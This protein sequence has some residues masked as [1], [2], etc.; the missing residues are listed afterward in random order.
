MVKTLVTCQDVV[1][2][3]NGS[4]KS[5]TKCQRID[6]LAI[7]MYGREGR[8]SISKRR[9]GP[10]TTLISAWAFSGLPET[11]TRTRYN[12]QDYT[13]FNRNLRLSGIIKSEKQGLPNQKL[14][15]YG[16]HMHPCFANIWLLSGR[17]SVARDVLWAG[18]LIFGSTCCEGWFGRSTF[19]FQVEGLF[20][21]GDFP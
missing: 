9:L 16:R 21:M 5:D 4:P 15:D 8:T 7:A 10:T 2:Y 3:K 19:N 11:S 14:S 1:V 18:I 12:R 13:P 20:R 6:S 17:R